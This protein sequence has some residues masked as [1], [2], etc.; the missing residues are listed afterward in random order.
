MRSCDYEKWDVIIDCPSVPMKTKKGTEEMK[1]KQ[2]SEWIDAKV[3][4]VQINFKAINIRIA[5]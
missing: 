4:K 2:R 5:F 1:P 3:K